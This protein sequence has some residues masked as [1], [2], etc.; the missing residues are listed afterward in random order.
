MLPL[1]ASGGCSSGPARTAS[2]LALMLPPSEIPFWRPIARGFE[3]EHPGATVTLVEGP[4]STDARENL[5]TASLLAGDPFFDLVY[6]DV[7]WTPKFAAAGWLVALDDRISPEERQGFL[8]AALQAGSFRG[9]LYRVPV[10]TDVGLLFY[11]SDWL[12]EAGLDPPETFDDLIRIARALQDPPQR[13]GFVW[14][15]K[16]YEGLICVFLEVLTGYGG[17]WVDP[18]TLEVGLDRPPALAALT[19]LARCRGEA[20]VSPP[21]VSTY[22]EEESR[23]LFQDGRAVFLRNW[24]YTWRLAQSEESPLRG[25]VGVR[26]MVSTPEGRPAGTLGGWGLGLSAFSRNPD[27]AMEFMRYAVSTESQRLLCRDTGYAPARTAS[28]HDPVLLAAN[29]FLSELEA[30]H[31][32]AVARPAIPDYSL[33]SDILQRHL[34]AALAGSEPPEEAL[35][36]AARETR[37]LLTPRLAPASANHR[38]AAPVEAS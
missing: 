34:S 25:R 15:G 29:P 30:A 26:S 16:Q 12:I 21:G 9:H 17:F 4:Q 35:R 3:G 28:Y 11:R 2:Q 10:R 5:Y 32:N 14:Q 13:W 24:P 31:R 8:P 23:R 19:F 37:L 33:A 22:Q 7:T 27:L 18:V 38:R 6:L 36:R 1:C 20:A